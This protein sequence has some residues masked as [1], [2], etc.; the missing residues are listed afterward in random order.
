MGSSVANSL[1]VLAEVFRELLHKDKWVQGKPGMTVAMPGHS[2]DSRE[3]II[4][5][6]QF[7]HCSALSIT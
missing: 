1:L 7:Q 6:G 3:I 5:R 2:C 4:L